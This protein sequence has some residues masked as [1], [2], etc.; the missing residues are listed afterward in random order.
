M[1]PKAQAVLW[2]RDIERRYG[3]S[4]VTRWRWERSGNLPERDVHL[5]NKS[6]WLVGTILSAELRVAG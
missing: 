6:G 2:P 1:K 4:A 3:I 5:G